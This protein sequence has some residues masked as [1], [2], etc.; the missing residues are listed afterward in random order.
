MRDSFRRIAWM[1]R[2]ELIAILRDP[3]LRGLLF[4][5][6]L[7]QLVIF[8]YAANM[9]VRNIRTAVVDYDRT[10]L[11]RD[12][13][14]RLGAGDCFR[15][16]ARFDQAGAIAPAID[17]GEIACAVVIGQGFMERLATGG[18]A[19]VQAIHDGTDSSRA[20]LAINYLTVIANRFA[21]ES[22]DRRLRT[23]NGRIAAQ[24]GRPLAIG[25]VAVEPRAWFNENLESC[26]F[27]VP[28]IVGTILVLVTLMLTSMAIVREKEIGTMEQLLVTPIQPFEIILGKTLPFLATG[29]AQA[30]LI[31]LIGI[32]WFGVPFRGSLA[33]LFLG[34]LLHLAACLGLGIL[35][36]TLADT[37]QQ[38]MLLTSLV[39]LPQLLLSG[40]IFP[41]ANMPPPVQAFTTVVP[42]RYFLVI[43]RGIF[44]KGNGVA[45]LWP[46]FA[47]LALL[48]AAILA[49][50]VSRF[51]KRLD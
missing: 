49:V 25:S 13:I 16:V 10:P 27:F 51:H 44:L 48:G 37:Q 21:R 43:V 4:L 9:D 32:H 26:N 22:L 30:S 18:E 8:G 35:I 24:G 41:I 33:L 39:F 42:L 34:I 45:V 7:I 28:G 47:R 36:S 12:F 1:V 19:R 11:S 15:L 14:E 31:I 5:P 23:L 50:A 40:F 20:S 29:L 17:R 38:A 46:Q 2:K 3:K 6:P